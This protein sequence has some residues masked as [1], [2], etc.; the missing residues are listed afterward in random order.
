MSA[1][2]KSMACSNQKPKPP[3]ETDVFPCDSYL[4]TRYNANWERPSILWVGGGGK[5]G[6][7]C[8]PPSPSITVLS[9]RQFANNCTVFQARGCS[10]NLRGPSMIPGSPALFALHNLTQ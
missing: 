5:I 7:F 4:I 6:W 1:G 9:R 8:I 2:K 10:V 3:C